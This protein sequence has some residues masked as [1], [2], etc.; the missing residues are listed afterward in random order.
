MTNQISVL[1]LLVQHLGFSKMLAVF[2]EGPSGLP[3]KFM[4]LPNY[5]FS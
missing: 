1:S 4:I 5:P 3:S 2:S